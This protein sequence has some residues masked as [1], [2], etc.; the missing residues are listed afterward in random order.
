MM[1]AGG[2]FLKIWF[3]LSIKGLV[4]AV[5]S[6]TGC[7]VK[8]PRRFA[9]YGSNGTRAVRVEVFTITKCLQIAILKAP[10][11]GCELAT[12]RLIVE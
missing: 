8:L 10:R 5:S 3:T 1:P 2:L 11:A 9:L 12:I 4:Q 6:E 7:V